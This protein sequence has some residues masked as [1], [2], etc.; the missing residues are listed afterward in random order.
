MDHARIGS[1]AQLPSAARKAPAPG[2]EAIFS[3]FKSLQSCVRLG[4]R[5]SLGAGRA[6]AREKEQHGEKL[7]EVVF[8]GRWMA[9]DKVTPLVHAICRRG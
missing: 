1:A 7:E 2:M 3:E 6:P 9:K 4:N 8:H 5:D